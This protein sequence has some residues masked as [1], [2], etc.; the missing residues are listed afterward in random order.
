MGDTTTSPVFWSQIERFQS[1]SYSDDDGVPDSNWL[2]QDKIKSLFNKVDSSNLKGLIQFWAPIKTKSGR[3]VLAT[4]DQ[5]FK[6][7][8]VNNYSEYRVYCNMYQYSIDHG[9]DNNKGEN[10]VISGGPPATVFLNQLPEVVLHLRRR[11][12]TQGRAHCSSCVGVVECCM[13]LS[14]FLKIFTEVKRAL[15]TVGMSTFNVQ[16][17]RL[18]K[19]ELKQKE[20]LLSNWLVSVLIRMIV[21]IENST[22]GGGLG[23]FEIFQGN[24]VSPIPKALEER[25]RFLVPEDC[26]SSSS[27]LAVT[28]L[29]SLPRE[30]VKQQLGRSTNETAR[31]LTGWWQGPNFVKRKLTDVYESEC[32]SNEEVDNRSANQDDII[33]IKLECAG[34]SFKFY[35]HNSLTLAV[36]KKEINTHG[37]LNPG[38]YKLKYLDHDRD[39]ILMNSDKHLRQCISNLTFVNGAHIRLRVLQNQLFPMKNT[40][41]AAAEFC[42]CDVVQAALPDEPFIGMLLIKNAISSGDLFV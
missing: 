17:C 24:K 38:T 20:G 1:N 16:G 23:S 18:Y 3:L 41:L 15:K 19:M 26:M 11:R 28:H 37:N 4:C 7:E 39:W 21:F 35:Q 9:F 32:D 6:L 14:C 13:E 31:N 27:S 33:S 8:H 10:A 36:L 12:F 42:L 34:K 40:R 29:I 25:R 22:G 2:I 5:P 30:D